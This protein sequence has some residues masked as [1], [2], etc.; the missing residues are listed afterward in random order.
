MTSHIINSDFMYGNHKVMKDFQ[1]SADFRSIA[2]FNFVDISKILSNTIKSI[3][4]KFNHKNFI[5]FEII[6]VGVSKI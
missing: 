1:N 4:S 6:I 5:Q 3:Y 2:I